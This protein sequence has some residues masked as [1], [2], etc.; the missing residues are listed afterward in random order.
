MQNKM[1]KLERILDPADLSM[2]SIDD[3]AFMKYMYGSEKKNIH[4]EVD[5]TRNGKQSASFHVELPEYDRADDV[6]MSE[7]ILP[8]NLNDVMKGG[9]KVSGKS[10]KKN[11]KKQAAVY[12]N[13]PGCI[14][15]EDNDDD[16]ARL[17]KLSLINMGARY[18]LL[19]ANKMLVDL[20]I[21][22]RVRLFTSTNRRCKIRTSRHCS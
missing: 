9:S 10:G 11:D 20:D 5:A 15:E 1:K 6:N 14:R 13:T 18:E 2:N 8:E 16:M 21:S 3:N 12:A 19:N 7:I 22:L 17:G 4:A